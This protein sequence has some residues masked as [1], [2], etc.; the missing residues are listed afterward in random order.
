M[1]E[2]QEALSR[3]LFV[4]G[5]GYVTAMDKLTGEEVWRT[6]L[7]GTGYRFVN[8]LIEDGAVFAASGG[9]LFSLSPDNG[10]IRWQNYMPG[11]GYDCFALATMKNPGMG[12]AAALM[13]RASRES[14]QS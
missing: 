9:R 11:L 14:Q 12:S 4:G 5:F 8:L 10:E 6:S 1:S 13:E 2:M 3:I 7:P